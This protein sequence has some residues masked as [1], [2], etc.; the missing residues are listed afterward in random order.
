M[1]KSLSIGELIKFGFATF[2]AHWK[3]LI[4]SMLLMTIITYFVAFIAKKVFALNPL[5]G[6]PFYLIYLFVYLSLSL[7]LIKIFLKF[8]NNETP[9]IKDL[10]TCSNLTPQYLVASILYFLMLIAGVLLLVFPFFIWATKYALFPYFIVDKNQGAIEALKSSDKATY[11]AKWD[12]LGFFLAS[13]L[14]TLG[15]IAALCIGVFVTGPIFAVAQAL[16]YRKL[17][18]QT[19][20]FHT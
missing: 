8:S 19:T 10:F 4:G 2:K 9:L 20:E 17:V 1:N 16:A 7:G 6:V 12:Y 14:L 15:G 11:G 18:A 3:F 5:L 13:F